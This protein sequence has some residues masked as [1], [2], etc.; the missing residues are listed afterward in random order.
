MI[1]SSLNGFRRMKDVILNIKCF[2]STIS[3][4]VVSSCLNDE[5]LNDFFLFWMV[6]VE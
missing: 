4:E 1:F 3:F 2:F 5:I 6:L